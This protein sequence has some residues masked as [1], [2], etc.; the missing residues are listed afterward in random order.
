MLVTADNVIKNL[1]FLQ[2]DIIVVHVEEFSV[3]IV[4]KIGFFYHVSKIYM[5]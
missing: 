5:V 2:E 4:V 1:A 3:M